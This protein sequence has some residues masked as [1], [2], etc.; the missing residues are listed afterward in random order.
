[1][2]YLL[3]MLT[4]ITSTAYAEN[5]TFKTFADA[6]KHLNLVYQDY[7]KKLDEDKRIAFVKTQKAW[8]DFKEMDCNYL[9]SSRDVKDPSA[10]LTECYKQHTEFR[11]KLINYYNSCIENDASC[12]PG[13]K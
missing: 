8:I 4:L 5:L 13:T 9:A 6:E 1:M 2:R 3:I 10:I 11:I 12:A 7:I